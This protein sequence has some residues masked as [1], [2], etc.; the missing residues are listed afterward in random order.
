MKHNLIAFIAYFA[1]NAFFICD[2]NAQW[3]GGGMGGRRSGAAQGR[4]SADSRQDAGKPIQIS[5]SS[6]QL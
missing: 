3:G 6:D 2:A 4:G 1:L 5:N